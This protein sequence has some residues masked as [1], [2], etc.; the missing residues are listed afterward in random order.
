MEIVLIILLILI[1]LVLGICYYCFRV[2]FYAAPRKKIEGEPPYILPPG[3]E[4]VPYGEKMLK[5]M[6]EARERPHEQVWIESYDGLKLCANYYEGIPGAPIEIM[7]HGYRGSAER[8]LC[9]G[10]QRAFALGRNVLLVDQRCGGNSEGNVIT[11]GIRERH[12]CMKWID[13]VIGRFGS[14]VQI[15]LA[16]VSMGAATVLMTADMDL[17]K[18]VVGIVGDCG[19]TS[20]KDIICRVIETEMHLLPKLAYPFVKLA[21]RLYGGFDLE[22]CSPLEAV[23]NAKVPI[24]FAHGEADNFVPCEMTLRMH[25]ACTSEKGLLTVPGAAHGLSY[26]AAPE[27]YLQALKETLG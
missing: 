7:F 25:E 24:F 12:D 21:A 11:F 27:K 22:E 2:A 16:G 4:Y 18:N 26:P 5:W 20:P 8:D 10:I 3:E 1:L 13:Y 6:R 9:G 14:D 19:Y 17:P 23:K 15:I